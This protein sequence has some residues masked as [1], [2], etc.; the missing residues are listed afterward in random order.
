MPINRPPTTTNVVGG[1]KG[2]GK[3]V[4]RSSGTNAS[5]I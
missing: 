2:T 3:A 5:K 4:Y 1:L